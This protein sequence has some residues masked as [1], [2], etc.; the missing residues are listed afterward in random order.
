M[1]YSRIFRMWRMPHCFDVNSL[2]FRKTLDCRKKAVNVPEK[3]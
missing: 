3:A 1:F 2:R